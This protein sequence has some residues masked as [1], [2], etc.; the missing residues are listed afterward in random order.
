MLGNS[1]DM[2][3]WW[4]LVD[5]FFFVRW[6]FFLHCNLPIAMLYSV[7]LCRPTYLP[8]TYPSITVSF[9]LLELELGR[10]I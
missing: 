1:V 4:I 3:S 2:V 10:P 7:H 5:F 9:F 6:V 8:L